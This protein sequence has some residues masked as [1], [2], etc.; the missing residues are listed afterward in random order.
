MHGEV[1]YLVDLVD[2][3]KPPVIEGITFTECIIH[4]PAVLFL[5]PDAVLDDNDFNLP[6]DSPEPLLFEIE[7][8][9]KTGLLP[10][11]ASSFRR[12]SFI[13]V[14]FAGTRQE[15]DKFRNQE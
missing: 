14:G 13:N 5:E 3:S 7:P 1:V 11:R 6:I 8:G 10:V 15:L 9:P 4:G 2:R 12:C